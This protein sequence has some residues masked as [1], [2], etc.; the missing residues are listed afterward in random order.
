M[1]QAEAN[2]GEGFEPRRRRVGPG[3]TTTS[4]R[5]RSADTLR[6][7]GGGG[8]VVLFT[9]LPPGSRPSSLGRPP[10]DE[11]ARPRTPG[12]TA[13]VEAMSSPLV[14]AEFEFETFVERYP[15]VPGADPEFDRTRS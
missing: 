7:S 6:P 9:S 10:V 8:G 13:T 11:Y 2:G 3:A 4:S 12:F 15:V 14:G 1:A 5:P